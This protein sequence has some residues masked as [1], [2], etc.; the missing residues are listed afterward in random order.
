MVTAFEDSRDNKRGNSSESLKDSG[1]CSSS[2]GDN[3]NQSQ[4]ES[5]SH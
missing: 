1:K 2:G 3:T 5:D 4:D